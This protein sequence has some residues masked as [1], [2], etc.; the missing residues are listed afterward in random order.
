MPGVQPGLGGASSPCPLPCMLPWA[1]GHW[2]LVEGG[3]EA[4]KEA[5]LTKGCAPRTGNMAAPVG[6]GWETR[7]PCSAAVGLL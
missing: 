2:V 3:E 5:V 1:V 4:L 7:P 6:R